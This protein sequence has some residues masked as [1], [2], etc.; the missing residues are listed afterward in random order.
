MESKRKEKD[1]YRAIKNKQNIYKHKKHKMGME[2]GK[3]LALSLIAVFMISFLAGVV[4]AGFWD[5]FKSAPAK[6]ET[7]TGVQ[8]FFEQKTIRYI[9]GIVFGLWDV[10]NVTEQYAVGS[11]VVNEVGAIIAYLALWIALLFAFGNI[12]AI[13]LPTESWVGWIIGIA[14][15]IAAAQLK[16]VFWLISLF[17]LI[18]AW[19]G[20]FSVF[21]SIIIAFLAFFLLSIGTEHLRKW[22]VKRKLAIESIKAMRG[23]H[24]VSEGIKTLGQVGEEIGKA[25]EGTSKI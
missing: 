24:K 14:L 2:A 11:L 20:T 6:S 13:F 4:S 21:A 3:I 25:G 12:I 10:S 15:T 17:A 16:F 7:E 5:F 8:K 19:L 22:A 9:V 23:R 18:T 1:N